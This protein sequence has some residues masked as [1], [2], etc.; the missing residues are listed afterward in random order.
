[1]FSNIYYNY[2]I[3]L[4]ILIKSQQQ[5]IFHPEFSNQWIGEDYNKE[6]LQLETDLELQA[7]YLYKI[8]IIIIIIIIK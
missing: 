8:K 7:H 4:I 6:I 2:I 3:F 1:M 5:I